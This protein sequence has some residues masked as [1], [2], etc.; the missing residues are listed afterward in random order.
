[1]SNSL[2][3]Y[4]KQKAALT[5]VPPAAERLLLPSTSP[6]PVNSVVTEQIQL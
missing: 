4:K 1:M 6:T 2:Q 5:N 3:S